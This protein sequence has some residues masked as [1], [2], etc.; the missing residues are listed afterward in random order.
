MLSEV[1]RVVTFGKV[2]SGRKHT[3]V[4]G[5]RNVLFLE[6]GTDYKGVLFIKLQ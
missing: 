1:R 5:A 6:L 2:I 3:G 4:L